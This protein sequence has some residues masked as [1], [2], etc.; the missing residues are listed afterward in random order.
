[1]DLILALCYHSRR[2]SH[3][4]ASKQGVLVLGLSNV[5]LSTKI[6]TM[7]AIL[8][9]HIRSPDED[10]IDGNMYCERVISNVAFQDV[11]RTTSKGA[12]NSA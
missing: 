10:L 1:M 9:P 11:K 2:R 8:P 5:F 6:L 4:C 3:V 7:F 12:T